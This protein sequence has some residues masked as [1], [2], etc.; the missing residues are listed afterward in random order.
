MPLLKLQ[1]PDGSEQERELSRSQ[2]LSIG[3]QSFND[4]CV[5][6]DGVGAMHCRI[7][8]NKAAF[9]V[10]AA[11]ASGVDVNGTSV[12]RAP[13]QSG[14]IIRIGSLDLV[15]VDPNVGNTDDEDFG[16]RF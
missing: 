2:P 14:D 5:P 6:D 3:R 15:Y 10:T 12:A 11:T 16:I 9:E 7:S 4:V 1:Y 13:L 8:W